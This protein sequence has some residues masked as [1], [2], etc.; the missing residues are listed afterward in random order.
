[1]YHQRNFAIFYDALPIA[2]V[3]GTISSRMRGTSAANNV[4]AKTGT[5]AYARCLSG[6][7]KTADGE[8]LA[9][10]MIANNFLVPNSAVEYV[11][12]T[13]LE[14]LAGFRRGGAGRD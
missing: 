7:V 10:A 4:H 11:Q 1:M 12:D 9:F 8:M 14:Y 5:I 3:D 13:A 2:G 6:Y